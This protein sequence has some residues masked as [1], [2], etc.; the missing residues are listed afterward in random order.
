MLSRGRLAFAAIF[1]P[2]TEN[3]SAGV[4]VV[5]VATGVPHGIETHVTGGRA[6]TAATGFPSETEALVTDERVTIAATRLPHQSR[7]RVP[8]TGRCGKA[9]ETAKDRSRRIGVVCKRPSRSGNFPPEGERLLPTDVPLG[10]QYTPS[11]EERLLLL[12]SSPST[13]VSRLG[14]KW[15][16]RRKKL[17]CSTGTQKNRCRLENRRY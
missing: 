10:H 9:A 14:G 2:W 13:E 16:L 4:R 3:V 11:G 17:K 6:T 15:F 1:L 5:I 12:Y 8:G 7:A